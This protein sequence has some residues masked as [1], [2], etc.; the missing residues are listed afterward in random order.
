MHIKFYV[1]LLVVFISS[2][3]L[4]QE[5]NIT[6]YLKMIE[7]GNIKEASEALISM[8]KKFPNDPS[9]KF[10]EAV[11]TE[12]GSKANQMYLEIFEQYPK[13]NYADASLYRIFSF[14]YSAGIYK[15]A[16]E[17][18]K[19][20]INNYPSSPYVKSTDRKL[21][22]DEIIIDKTEPEIASGKTQNEPVE[23]N[24]NYT[25]Q[26]GAF[27]NII[28]AQNLK[29]RFISDGYYSDV[30]PK[31]IGGSILNVVTVGQFKEKD[32]AEIFLGRLKSVYKIEGRIISINN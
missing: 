11:L 25:I 4:A 21:P 26:A 2:T 12:D 14:Y 24:L 8:Q 1:V 17:Y 9:V 10:L 13:S 18:R 7:S 3:L 31:E 28:N 23:R 6:P 15:K 32:E 19:L 22:D 30:F 27:L 5:Q 16:E 29:A 20:L